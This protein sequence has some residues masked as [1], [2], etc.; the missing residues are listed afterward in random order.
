[1][2]TQA[3]HAPLPPAL[4]PS[5]LDEATAARVEKLIEEEEGAQHRFAGVLKWLALGVALAMALFHLW[6]AWDIVPTTTLRFVH[7]GFALVL[8][9]LLFPAARRFR[10]RLM[11]WDYALIAA[12]LYVTWYL[13]AGGDDL[14][15]RYV[16]PEPLDLLV[17][18]ALILLV[19]EVTRRSTGWVMPIV[20]AAFMLYAFFGNHLPPPWRHQGYDE[21]RLIPH[22]TLTLDGIFGPAVDVSSSIIIL[23]CRP[24]ARASSS[25]TSPLPP[26]AARRS[27]PG[28]PWCCRPFC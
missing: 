22:I 4:A 24:A 23:F 14:L 13:I 2:T 27:A 10:H 20:A 11:P 21:V 9:F 17:G 5:E 1:V 15:D 6:A 26:P 7:V 3:Q 18:W 8:G 19:L 28:A 25:S 12:G 16:F